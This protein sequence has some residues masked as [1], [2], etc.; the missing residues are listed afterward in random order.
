MD[1]ASRSIRQNPTGRLTHCTLRSKVFASGGS[2][3]ILQRTSR[4][5]PGLKFVGPSKFGPTM[6]FQVPSRVGGPVR[7]EK[8]MKHIASRA[9]RLQR[10]AA[11]AVELAVVLP[12]LAFIFVVAVDYCRIFYYSLTIQNAARSGAFYAC[13]SASNSIDTTGIQTAAHNDTS[14]LSPAPTVTSSTSVDKDGNSEVAV[15]VSYTFNTITGFP[16]VPSSTTLNRTASMRV[17]P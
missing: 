15:T 11:A 3:F 17:W 10:R 6:D 13:Q 1:G 7:S 12:F 14:N 2:D 5:Q 9:K 16:G 8:S 4:L